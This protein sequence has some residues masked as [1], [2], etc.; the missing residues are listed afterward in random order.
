MGVRGKTW[1]TGLA[2]A[3]AATAVLV[4]TAATSAAA[5]PPPPNPSDSE[6]DAGRALAGAKATQVG[7][8]ASR[9]AAAEA[10]LSALSDDVELKL[11]QANKALEDLRAAQ[12]AADAAEAAAVSAR[13][14]SE[15][16]AAQVDLARADL[17]R[18][19]AVTFQQGQTMG[20]IS[21]LLGAT[22]P[23]DFLAR[24]QLLSSVSL[25]RFSALE[26]MERARTDKANKDAAAREAL[27]TAQQQK[28]AADLARSE[29]DAARATAEQAR[30]DQAAETA[31]LE[32]DRNS[33]EQQLFAAQ[34]QVD[35]LRNQRQR[36]QD[37]LALRQ[38]E[39]Q[40]AVHKIVFV[41]NGTRASVV[42]NGLV[43]APASDAAVERVIARAMSQAGMPY[44]WGGGNADGPTLGL[45][46]G[47]VADAHGDF[48]KR[49]FDCSGLMVYAFAGV[50]SLPHY[51]GYQYTAGRQVPL[52]QMRRGDLLFWGRRSIHHVALYLG[53]GVM[54]E[55]PE[56]GQVVRV[57]R[58]RYRE[59]LPNATRLIG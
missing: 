41:A 29:A 28:D 33:V 40:E 22:S 8:L 18:L 14:E 44:A 57:T 45:R 46:D 24:E 31:R 56:S 48:R 21:A 2:V 6:I 51:S 30:Q 7:R 36:Y 39:E 16:A 54:I 17:D 47:G 11:E 50:V 12:D 15:A 19:V 59:I 52:S 58:V 34:Q 37:W 42:R 13:K 4:T 5:P 55:A 53:D 26:S 1:L 3:T 27:R 32:A 49:G 20:S 35:G 9:L 23:R 25:D 43:A 10:R 38:R